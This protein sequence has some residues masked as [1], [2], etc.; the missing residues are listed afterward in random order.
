MAV[1]SGLA[2]YALSYQISPIILAGGLAQNISGGKLPVINIL[3]SQNFPS[4][5]TGPADDTP[6]DAYFAHF[7]PLPGSSLIDNEIAHWP[8]ANQAV[9][10]NAVITKPL[11]ISLRMV[12]PAKGDVTVSQKQ[13]ILTNLQSSLSQHIS[14]GG[15]FDVATPSFI[16]TGCLLVAVHDVSEVQEGGQVQIEYD[17]EFEQPL[18]TLAQA[19]IAM[20]TAMAKISSGTQTAGDP[21]T[22]SVAASSVGQPGSNVAQNVVPSAQNTV[23]SQVSVG[24]STAA[25]PAPQVNTAGGVQVPSGAF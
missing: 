4:G 6:L 5:A 14:L 15:W 13:S 19:Q 1:S 9:A 12:C 20:N 11:K 8:F 24:A 3:S 21:P 25:S 23:G 7:M 22:A 2:D 18:I 17:W 16:Y 10:A